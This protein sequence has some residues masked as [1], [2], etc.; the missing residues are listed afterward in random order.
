MAGRG[1]SRIVVTKNQITKRLDAMPVAL[2][3]MIWAVLNYEA[4]N[5]QGY[6]QSNAP[7]QDQTGNARQGLK[8]RPERSGSILTGAEYSIELFHTMPYGIYLETR[9][10]GKYAIIKPTIIKMGPRVMRTLRGAMGRI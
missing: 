4:P 7:W 1:G 8:A 5:V 10:S 2:D 9:W 6:A 3:Q